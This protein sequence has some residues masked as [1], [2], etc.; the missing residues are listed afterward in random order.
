MDEDEGAEYNP[1]I[2]PVNWGVTSHQWF[3]FIIPTTAQSVWGMDSF[4]KGDKRLMRTSLEILKRPYVPN[5]F[6]HMYP[7][8]KLMGGL[9]ANKIVHHWL[10][11]GEKDQNDERFNEYSP[12][13]D[14]YALNGV[15]VMALHDAMEETWEA[16]YYDII[17]RTSSRSEDVEES[18]LAINLGEPTPHRDRTRAT[19]ILNTQSNEGAFIEIVATDDFIGKWERGSEALHI[20]RVD[21][22]IKNALEDG[23]KSFVEWVDGLD[24][25]RVLLVT[26]E[27]APNWDDDDVIFAPLGKGH[28]VT[29]I[30]GELALNKRERSVATTREDIRAGRFVLFKL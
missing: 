14:I 18:Q 27:G 17:R 2:L 10:A 16:F 15:P 26:E 22:K 8:L 11:Y 25:E 29:W 12:G 6:M 1:P 30:Y 3:G 19:A 5:D 13:I 7:N 24:R 4:L 21:L 20:D 23:F 9:L 28:P